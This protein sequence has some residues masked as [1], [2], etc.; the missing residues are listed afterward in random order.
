MYA[1][2]IFCTRSLGTN[3]VLETFPVGRRLAFDGWRGRLWAVCPR[4]GRWNLSAIEERWEAV[5]D[6]EKLFRSARLRVQSENIGLARLPDG[7]ELIRVGEA[8]PGEMAAWR[9]GERLLRRHRYHL[10]VAGAAG[11]AGLGVAGLWAV[12]AVGFFGVWIGSD[13]VSN[14]M[15]RRS[16][17]RTIH[18]LSPGDSPTGGPLLVQ[19][20][21]LFGSRLAMDEH[22]ALHLHLPAHRARWGS[23]IVPPLRTIPEVTLRGGAAQRVL[24]RA[25]IHV[26]EGGGSRA[27][28]AKAVDR[29]ATAG[30]PEALLR[31]VVGRGFD[32]GVAIASAPLLEIP[33]IYRMERR[34]KRRS[35]DRR[36]VRKLRSTF[37]APELLALEMALNEESERQAMAGELAALQAAWREAEEIAA[38]AD[39]LTGPSIP[40]VVRKGRP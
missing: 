39:S 28:V 36:R 18:M 33:G 40:D 15:R 8:L 4:C 27:V 25:M 11:A 13:L 26:N 12:G 10:L 5:E 34:V 19:E 7:T 9:Y 23:L 3:D 38:I 29:L 20:A 30:E 31:D 32:I 22:D 35:R 17:R 21:H 2:C 14:A 37:Q 24:S 1:S 16:E 6:S